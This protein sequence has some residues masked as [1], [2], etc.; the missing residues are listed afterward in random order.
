MCPLSCDANARLAKSFGVRTFRCTICLHVTARTLPAILLGIVAAMLLA[1]RIGAHGD[2]SA[3]TRLSLILIT[4]AIAV[5]IALRTFFEIPLAVALLVAGAPA[6]AAAA[7]LFAG[8]AINMASLVTVGREAGWKA[9][10]V[11]TAMVWL[12]TVVGGLTVE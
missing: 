10:A 9:V 11:M 7:L 2:L 5:P 8:P 12:V 3:G 6:G 1:D 4:A